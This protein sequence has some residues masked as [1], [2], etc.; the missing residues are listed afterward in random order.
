MVG[1]PTAAGSVRAAGVVREAAGTS[2]PVSG[3]CLR[4]VVLNT[5]KTGPI[6]P[7]CALCWEA[8]R[9]S[10]WPL[11]MKAKLAAWAGNGFQQ[12]YIVWFCTELRLCVTSQ[13]SFWGVHGWP[14]MTRPIE[15]MFDGEP[16]EGPPRV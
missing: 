15:L 1:V 10:S 11:L 8:Q 5:E 6:R 13:S 2:L 14:F 9:A 4:A 16:V 3:H 7:C 12:E